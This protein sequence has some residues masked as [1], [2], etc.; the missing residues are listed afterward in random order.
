MLSHM[1]RS[2]GP[3]AGNLLAYG[4]SE[5]AA[6]ASRLLVVIAVARS[7]DATAIGL[8]AAALAAADILKS[9][10][11]NG[12]GQRIIAASD[13]DL[14]ATCNAAHR[15]FWGWSLGLFSLQVLIGLAAA[16]IWG[17]WLFFVLLTI[18][19]LEYLFMPGGLV[20]AALAMRAGMMRRTAAI[21]GGQVVGA[22]LF[23]VVLVLVMPGPLALVIPRL[24]AA[25]IWLLAIRRLHPWRRNAAAG[26][27]PLRHFTGFGAAVL[28]VE[29]VKALRLHADKLVIGAIAGAEVLG[30]YFLAFNAG[31]GLA[32]SFSVA[33]SKV[34]F[35][36][37]TQAADREAALKH[38]VTMAVGIIAP[39]VVLQALLAPW[40]V[41]L[42]LGADWAHISPVVS[43][44][45]L[46]A[47]PAVLWSATAQWLRTQDR[48][49]T[50]FSRTVMM[51]G[52]L[53]GTTGLLAPHGIEVI[54]WGYLIVAGLTQTSFAMPALM[55][56]FRPKL[57]KA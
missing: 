10:T 8:A 4:A 19:A 14:D 30:V 2:G 49:G 1:I 34:L 53:I 33:F 24:L 36:H 42:M 3:F 54:A 43:I 47:I 28:G 17:D 23:T 7:M 57:L 52:A 41:P 50:E 31:L 51:T 40:Y 45:C 55:A 32:N 38:A 27:V 35:P 13:A 21:A 48:A 39:V 9:L 5:V 22:N 12:V 18:L 20:Q 26:L 56:A 6:K 44:L 11:E 37:L 15:I 46:A 25:P 16:M 29:L